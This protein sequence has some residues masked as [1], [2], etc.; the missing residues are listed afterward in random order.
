MFDQQVPA[1]IKLLGAAVVVGLVQLLWAAGA[2]RGQQDLK[3]AAGPRDT[4]MPISGVAA[5]LDR[6][7]R[8]FMETFPFFAAGVLGCAL[9]ARTGA[10]L[11]LWGSAL[12]VS[13]RAI[14]VPLYAAGWRPIRSIIWGLSIVGLVM[15]LVALLR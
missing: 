6:A 15:V 5:R 11:T 4:P 8:N 7:F 13:M 3:W 10:P 2:A 14:Y 12:Y 9:T 1:E